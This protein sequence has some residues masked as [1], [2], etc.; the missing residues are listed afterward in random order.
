MFGAEDYKTR[1][2]KVPCTTL[3]SY[4]HTFVFNIF[5]VFNALYLHN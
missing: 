3:L 1:L 2:K 5:S 4:L